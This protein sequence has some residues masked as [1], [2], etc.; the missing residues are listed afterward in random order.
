MHIGTLD[1]NLEALAKELHL[2]ASDTLEYFRDGRR[3]S[4]ITERRIA[5]E[6]IQGRLAES[7]GAAYDVF[8]SQNRKWEVRSLT[9]GG[10]YFCPSYMVGSGRK[11]EEKGFLSKLSEIEGYFIA[12]IT[13]F[14]SIPV[15]RIE[16]TQV[17][18]WHKSGQLG[19]NSS[20]NFSKME[21][22]LNSLS[23]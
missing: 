9:R 5:R 6:F 20:V 8:D 1:W 2:S 11:F 22:L 17:M 18:Y 21:Q 4:F 15:Y 13:D 16:S 19:K 10:I 12:K 23:R 14:P 3:C 7:E